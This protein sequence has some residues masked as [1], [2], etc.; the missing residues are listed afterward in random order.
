MGNK[1]IE[2]VSK[3]ITED[4]DVNNFIDRITIRVLP[5]I[6]R[7]NIIASIEQLAKNLSVRTFRRGTQGQII[8]ICGF[9]DDKDAQRFIDFAEGLPVTVD[10][11]R[12]S[13]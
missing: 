10:V 6:S 7:Q 1:D 11:H 13:E 2:K 4:P 5:V 9:E 8:D 12:F 3:I